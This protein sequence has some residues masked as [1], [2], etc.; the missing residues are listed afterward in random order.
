MTQ[1]F[2][3]IALANN[4]VAENFHFER[5]ALDPVVTVAGRFWFNT[6]EKAF[7]YSSLDAQGAVIIKTIADGTDMTAVQAAI[8][9]ETAARVAADTAEVSA[10][11][12]AIA[13][14]LSD[15][16]AVVTALQAEL[17]AIE[18]GSGLSATGTYVAPTGSNYLDSTTS[19]KTADAALDAAVKL[20]ADAA[21]AAA[22][23]VATEAAARIAADTAIT[24]QIDN[25]VL[26]SGDGSAALKT[27]LNTRQFTITT[28]VAA[29]EHVITH[30]LNT[31]YYISDIKVQGNDSV[32]RN[33]IVPVEEIDNNSFRITLSE[34]RNVKVGVLSLA[35]IV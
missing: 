29:L 7:K 26:A 22:T 24:T 20:A 11:N 12:T 31:T 18:T 27:S 23:A 16:T 8:D 33:D 2:H 15:T 19:L 6:A 32:Y 3:G 13:T 34:A 30:N 17:D 4:S 10:R 5:L 21:A 25:L 9:I 14:A 28:T 35:P 1:K